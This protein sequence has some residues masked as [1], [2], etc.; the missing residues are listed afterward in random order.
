[1]MTF[2]FRFSCYLFYTVNKRTDRNY[3]NSIRKYSTFKCRFCFEGTLKSRRE[4]NLKR[5][6]TT[7]KPFLAPRQFSR[8]VH[9]L[10]RLFTAYR[11]N[12]TDDKDIVGCIILY[13]ELLKSVSNSLVAEEVIT[14][15]K[16]IWLI[17]RSRYDC[18]LADSNLSSADF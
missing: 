10:S 9:D 18:I 4:Q 8:Q 3:F 16:Y 14:Y 6:S 5:I 11:S 15:V 17:R 12:L 13:I 2:A 7:S 1:M